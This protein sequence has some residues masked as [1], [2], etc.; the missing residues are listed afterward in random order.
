MKL[1][2]SVDNM[3]HQIDSADPELLGRWVV[4]ILARTGPWL[5]STYVQVRAEPSWLPGEDGAP[6]RPD[7][8]ADSRIISQ[9]HIVHSPQEI[10][11]MLQQQI[12]DAE[13]LT[14]G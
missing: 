3:L 12:K 5:Q 8:I 9:L 6:W 10:V 11:D 7:W 4:E 2:I 13:A 14:G 1:Y